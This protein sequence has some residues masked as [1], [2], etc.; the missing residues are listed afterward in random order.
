MSASRYSLPS[1]NAPANVGAGGRGPAPSSAGA[2]IP[3]GDAAPGSI[4]RLIIFQRTQRGLDGRLYIGGIGLA[5]TASG[6]SRLVLATDQAQ[7]ERRHDGE[8]R[9]GCSASGHNGS[10]AGRRIDDGIRAVH[11]PREPELADAA[12]HWC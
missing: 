5:V 6:V 1:S 11:R 9:D 12:R 7:A 10:S 2:G 8:R 3:T 4:C